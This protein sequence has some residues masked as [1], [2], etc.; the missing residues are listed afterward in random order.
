MALTEVQIKKARPFDK[1]YILT[2]QNGLY[3]EVMTTGAKYWRVRYW[4]NKHERRIS[5]GEYPLVSLKEARI[6]RDEI[7][8]MIYEGKDPVNFKKIQPTETPRPTFGSVFDEWMEKR[9]IPVCTQGYAKQVRSR[10]KTHILPYLRDTSIASITSLDLLNVLRRIEARGTIDIAHRVKQICGQVFQYGIATG[11]CENDP[12]FPLRGALKAHK[13]KHQASIID[14][15]QVGALMAAIDSYPAT[16]VRCAMKFQA[17]T[18]VRPGELR[19]GEWAEINVPQ[20]E[21]IIPAEKMKMRRPHIV[22]LSVQAFEILEEIKICT[23]HGRYIFP[24]AR[25]PA[26]NRPM[27]ENGILA[28]LRSMGYEKGV[29]TGH[30]FRSTASTLLNA[31]GWNRDVIERQLAHQESNSVRASYNFAEYLPERRKM[32]Q[33]WADYLDELKAL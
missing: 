19:M 32:M 22:P 12:S 5:I 10:M 2:D 7:R 23:G 18:F 33:W 29:M 11:V 15:R 8:K 6:K 26:G 20:A 24:S 16:I 25:T 3:L 14:P 28:A 31:N 17:L 9:I 13:L 1:R 4:F 21:W 27:S 30:G